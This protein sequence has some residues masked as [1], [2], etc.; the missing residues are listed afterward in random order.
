MKT[1]SK[2]YYSLFIINNDR[3]EEVKRLNAW[4]LPTAILEADMMNGSDEQLKEKTLEIFETVREIEEI[5]FN[6]PNENSREPLW[7]LANRKAATRK[8]DT[9]DLKGGEWNE[10]GT[11]L[12]RE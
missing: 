4:S 1:F 8:R 7:R 2:S 10:I 12:R 5:D 11:L 3:I 9:W 6:D